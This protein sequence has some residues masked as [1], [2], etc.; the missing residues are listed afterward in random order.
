MIILASTYSLFVINAQCTFYVMLIHGMYLKKM[1]QE[2]LRH[3]KPSSCRCSTPSQA[4]QLP[5]FYA[6]TSSRCRCST[7]SQAEELSK[8]YATTRRAAV[9]VLRLHKP[10]SCRCSTPPH[11]AAVYVPHHHKPRSCRSATLPH[12]EELSMFYA[13]TSRAVVN[14]LRHLKRNPPHS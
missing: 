3:H 1:S 9:D 14:V 10:I 5:M 12:A 2:Y 13:I 11:R 8:C 4:D 6:T 7:P